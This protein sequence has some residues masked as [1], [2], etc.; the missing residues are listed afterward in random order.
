M[1]EKIDFLNRN[2]FIEN[3]AEII[4][5]TSFEEDNRAFAIDGKWG[6]GK[7][8]IVDKIEDKFKTENDYLIFRYNAWNYNYYDEPLVAIITS[9]IDQL[10]DYSTSGFKGITKSALKGICGTLF[11]I[12]KTLGK[13]TAIL[14]GLDKIIDIG[15]EAK[16]CKDK[17]KEE[18][19]NS[20][21][22][23]NN[24]IDNYATLKETLKKLRDC[25]L[26]LNKKIIFI[27]DEIDRCLPEYAIKLLERTHH[28]FNTLKGSMTIYVLSKTQ[29]G[30]LIKTYYGENFDIEL[31]MQKLIEFTVNVDV[32]FLDETKDEILKKYLR[33]FEVKEQKDIDD[34]ILFFKELTDDIEI[35]KRLR[36][37]NKLDKVH[38]IYVRE[39]CNLSICYFEI[40]YAIFYE[41]YQD[42]TAR[43]RSIKLN[44]QDGDLLNPKLKKIY[45]NTFNDIKLGS[46]VCMG[47]NGT[48]DTMNVETMT[49]YKH[50]LFVYLRYEQNLKYGEIKIMNDTKEIQSQINEN[51]KHID[52][53]IKGMK[54][55]V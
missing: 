4:K 51:Y 20:Q 21:T 12:L 48:F 31:Y 19:A 15:D 26:K 41:L 55:I 34:L 5:T 18:V 27:V 52:N 33:H 42:E 2:I 6:V 8:F 29:L 46:L 1:A 25:L 50:L 28:I 39:V 10:N 37:L 38:E 11:E 17:I 30:N 14:F 32:G 35:R 45:E 9:I 7:T 13:S 43:F 54:F 16:K 22:K 44:P 40:F 36:I 49:E 47:A 24:K 23:I 3:I 53:F